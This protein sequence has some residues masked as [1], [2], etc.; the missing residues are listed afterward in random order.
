MSRRPR[1]RRSRWPLIVIAMAAVVTL[2]AGGP[3]GV[4]HV[5]AGAIDRTLGQSALHGPLPACTIGDRVAPNAT[6]DDWDRTLLDTEFALARDYAPSDLVDVA[7]AGMNGEGAVRALVIL[8]LDALGRAARRDGIE[9]SVESAYRSYDAQRRTF[10][11]LVDAYGRAYAL[12]SA[13]RPGHSEHQLGTTLD[14][15]GGDTWLAT[16]AWQFGF[17]LSYPES[18]SPGYTC[19]KPESWHYR[20]VGRRRAAAIQ[21][22]GL[23]P[24]EWLW[25]HGNETP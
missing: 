11:S 2:V 14:L 8:D 17:V 25:Q 1:S 19:Y 6:L 13:A 9:L 16:N 10:D 7:E 21:A 3:D 12:E 23:S 22:S 24:R 5:I 18:R 4:A 20:Y 15:T